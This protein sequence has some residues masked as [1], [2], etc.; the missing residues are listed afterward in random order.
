MANDVDNGSLS[1][2]ALA[3][4]D[5]KRWADVMPL[6]EEAVAALRTAQSGEE[7][8]TAT[9]V[10]HMATA[11]ARDY[12][13]AAI[14][15]MKTYGYSDGV[16]VP[17]VGIFRLRWLDDGM[18]VL[19]EISEL[20][21]YVYEAGPVR[22]QDAAPDPSKGKLETEADSSDLPDD[23][24]ASVS[25]RLMEVNWANGTAE[26]HQYLDKVI[27]LRFGPELRD[28]MRRY[29]T[30]YIQVKGQGRFNE[31]DMWAAIQVEEVIWTNPFAGPPSLEEL[32]N[33]PNPKIFRSEEIIK[34]SE[35][36]DV[37][38]FARMVREER[39]LDLGRREFLE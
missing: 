31:Y 12:E 18:R 28:E 29:A 10:L 32:L 39:D 17:G 25:G 35:P 38:E 4:D 8:A 22:Q 5:I 19:E 3:V 24:P 1:F 21:R 6:V 33:N 36:F 27:P 16:K 9:Q 7:I 20:P 14:N 13:S 23:G 11:R 34:T 26:L 30:Y 2:E 15:T 37:D